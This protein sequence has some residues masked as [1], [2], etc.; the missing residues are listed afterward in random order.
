MSRTVVWFSAGA[1]SAVAAKLTLAG[2]DNLANLYI[3]YTNPGS[4]HPDNERFI[5][6]CERWFRH[7]VD[8]L[9]SDRYQDTW[10][11]WTKRR[12]IVGPT[13]ALCTAEL[14]KMVRY[15]YQQ[16]DDIQ[17]FGYTAEEAHRA[18][19]FRE[20]N[21]GV[22]LRTPLIDAG[23]T[24]DDCLA[25]IDRA[26][27]RLPVMYQLGYR[28]NNCL[29]AETEFI[30]DRGIRRLGDAVGESVRVRSVGGGWK[31]ATIKSFGTQPLLRVV[32]C[33]GK[34][35][36]EVFATPG[37]RW[38]IKPSGHD[39]T[40]EKTTVDLQESDRLP[41]VFGQLSP[42][43]RPSAFGI[44]HGIVFGDGTRGVSHR[45][46]AS[47]VLCGEKA[48]QLVKFFPLSPTK[49]VPAGIH[50]GD[51]PRSW[52]DAPRLDE[53]Q[54]Y[55]YGWLA[56]YFATDGCFSRGSAMLSSAKREHLETARDVAVQLGIGCNPIRVAERVGYGAEPTPLYTLPLIAD[57]LRDDFFL[58]PVHRA[59]FTASAR[60]KPHPWFVKSVEPTDRVEEVFCAVVPD[61]Q[62]FALEGN[63]LT[64]NC[65][66]CPKGGMGYWNKIRVD[67]P[68]AFNRM[69][70]LERDI[71]HSV[72]SDADGPI[73]LD[74]LD[75]ER[76]DHATE[77][78]FECSLLCVLAEQVIE[79]Q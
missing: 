1:A 76:G 65:I 19:R 30:T 38:L 35:E 52:K 16:P 8:R 15:A 42:L 39:P 27:I 26:G 34:Y 3:A 79:G 49:A 22:D 63:V 17:I 20:Q 61:G 54:S 47:V 4:E 62:A 12:F 67:F 71:G 25:I 10:D 13:G 9:R 28:N 66:G 58:M 5:N 2:A 44:S 59:R 75:P 73:W 51:L 78:S 48:N 68:D 40:T 74:E 72:L 24:K 7:P 33:R 31:D 64:G 18:D 14:K 53:S 69:A 41:S 29:A 43:V 55:L 60:R 37:H 23:L 36:R 46:S 21:P 45:S 50:V 77:P 57:T 6:D 70:V 56:G 11:V 32:M